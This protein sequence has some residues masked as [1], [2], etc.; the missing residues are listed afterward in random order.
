M[1]DAPASWLQRWRD[2]LQRRLSTRLVVASVALLVVVQALGLLSLRASID[3]NA[4]QSIQQ[5][6]ALG[7]RLFQRLLEQNGQRLRDGAGLLV[8]DYGFRSA[9]GSRDLETIASALGNHGRRIGATH[10]LLLDTDFALQAAASPPEDAVMPALQELAQRAQSSTV[11]DG[12]AGGLVAIDGRIHQL[13]MV[14]MR[15]PLVIAWVVMGFRVDEGLVR[16]MQRLSGL[17][18]ALHTRASA[19]ADW[20]TTASSL[21]PLTS[22]ALGGPASMRPGSANSVLIAGQAYGMRVAPLDAD[23]EAP[24]RALLLRSV[25]EAVAPYR[26]LQWTLLVIGLLGTVALAAGGLWAARRITTPIRELSGAAQ[27][28]AAGD[29]EHPV[30]VTTRDE[31]GELAQTF[32]HMRTSI[33]AQRK[34]VTR[35]AYWDSLTGLPNRAQFR[36]A[37]SAALARREQSAPEA[38]AAAST[39]TAAIL[40]LDLD[41]FKHINDLL[42]YATG[43]QLLR[44]V[45]ERLGAVIGARGFPMARLSGDEFALLL[46]EAELGEPM[47]AE[48]AS[49]F[50]RP[51]QLGEQSVDLRASVGIAHYPGHAREVDTL[52]ARAEVAMYAAKRGSSGVMVYHEQLDSGSSQT[53]SLLSDLQRAIGAGELRVFLQPKIALGSGELVGAEALL[54]WQHPTRG[55]VP[56]L[57]FIPFAEQTGFIRHLTLWVIDEILR[58]SP[59]LAAQGHAL[60]LA[61]NLSTRDLMDLELPDKIGERLARFA[62]PPEALKLEITESAIMDDP[63]RAE[64]VLARLHAMGLPLSIDDF[65][66]GYSSLAYLKRLPVKELKIDRSFVMHLD[67]EDGDHKIVRSTID[68]AHTLGL[69]VVAE[70]VENLAIWQVLRGLGCD[71]AQGYFV[72]RPLPA[73]QFEAWATAWPQ[74]RERLLGQPEAALLK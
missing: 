5:E 32:E 47:A 22:A 71:L 27:R 46:P 58:I 37:V 21:A 36:E 13:V 44:E 20:L 28:L 64:S 4:R 54:R 70:G 43:D 51:M 34:E 50:E 68:L 1:T 73:D 33:D 69:E 57:D 49:A 18:I 67:R 19:S 35:L 6:L 3:R 66:T 15:A 12:V 24:L 29:F 17:Q 38:T 40:L 45:G 53:L 23:N 10:A 62:V 30:P 2:R 74:Q 55:M 72:S 60:S 48:I 16:D 8:A 31:I 7:E 41:R 59:Q 56:P 39:R 11:G 9:V 65:G 26:S 63:Q 42:G 61:V 52:L 25:D 14:P